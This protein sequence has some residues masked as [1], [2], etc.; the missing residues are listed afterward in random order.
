MS[1]PA[2][3]QGELILHNKDI[4]QLMSLANLDI[5]QSKTSIMKV[6]ISEALGNFEISIP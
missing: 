1:E 3:N 4:T 5:K 6:N 2:Q